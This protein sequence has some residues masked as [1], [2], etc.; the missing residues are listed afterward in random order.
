MVGKRAHQI[1]AE[2][3]YRAD[4]AL[5]H[6][7]GGFGAVE[8]FLRGRL[9]PI[10]LFELIVGDEVYAAQRLDGTPPAGRMRIRG[11]LWIVLHRWRGRGNSPFAN[12][13]PKREFLAAFAARC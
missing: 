11:K 8:A 1:A 6:A 5:H 3:E 4:V 9:E 10:Q 7:L 13:R 2:V 12:V